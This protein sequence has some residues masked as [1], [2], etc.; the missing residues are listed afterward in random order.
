MSGLTRTIARHL[1]RTTRADLS[2]RAALMAQRSLLDAIGV[3]LGA[4][5]LEPACAPFARFAVEAGAGGGACTVLGFQLRTSPLMAAF[6]NGALAHA[7]DFEDTYDDAP[8]HPNAAC[9]PVALALAE[10]DP[11]LSG[12]QLITALALGSDLVCRLTRGLT[13]NPDRYGFYTPAI[14]GAYGAFATAG[15]LLGLSEDQLVAGFALTLSQATSSAQFKRDAHSPVRAVRDAFS[16]NAGLTAALLAAQGVGGFEAA[17][18]GPAGLYA[19]YAREAYD[20]ARITEQLGQRFLGE[21]VSFKPWPSCRGTHPFIEAALALRAQHG[22][23]PDAIERIE[24]QGAALN[25][26]LVEPFAQKRQPATAIDAKFSLPFCLGLAFVRGALSLD[27]FAAGALAE[28][29]VLAVA[30]RV[31]YRVDPE[32]GANQATSGR[33]ALVLR[34]G[35]SYERQF[36]RALGHPDNPLSDAGLVAKFVHCAARAHRP[37]SAAQ[38]QAAVVAISAIDQAPSAKRALRPVLETHAGPELTNVNLRS[39]A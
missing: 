19:L 16:V 38:A 4:S 39:N 36:E 32:L 20:P 25:L 6:A 12:T 28:R 5:G 14:M 13:E 27:D 33:L 10:R 2:A 7:L 31:V 3:S 24:C 22:I 35:S 1:A 26:M 17:L 34:G 8:A 15:K 21:A 37:L 18:E 30:Q 11:S 29:E 9:V 23:E